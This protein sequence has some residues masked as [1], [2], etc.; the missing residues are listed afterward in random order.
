MK[1]LLGL[2]VLLATVFLLALIG[3]LP[4]YLGWN[5]G[6][7]PASNNSLPEIRIGTAF[8]LSLF[9]GAVGSFFQ[10]KTVKIEK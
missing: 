9:L 7:V 10:T 1:V 2:L 4:V 5:F 3:A 8:W 6:V